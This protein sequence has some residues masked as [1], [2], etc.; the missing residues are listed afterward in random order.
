MHAVAI[1][2]V[3]IDQIAG[4]SCDVLS[5]Q[6]GLGGARIGIIRLAGHDH[7]RTAHSDRSERIPRALVQPARNFIGIRSFG[8][9]GRKGETVLGI[10]LPHAIPIQPPP[11]PQHRLHVDPARRGIRENVPLGRLAAHLRP[12]PVRNGADDAALA[13]R[14][15]AGRAYASAIPRLPVGGRVGIE[16]H[17]PHDRVLKP[18]V[19]AQHQMI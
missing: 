19:R 3:V 5:R 7:L 2:V 16:H 17:G 12:Q 14:I 11:K 1:D 10:H 18:P 15:P 6:A 8:A 13:R 4:L 9:V